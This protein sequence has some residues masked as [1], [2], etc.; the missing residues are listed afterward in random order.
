MSGSRVRPEYHNPIALNTGRAAALGWTAAATLLTVGAL[1]AANRLNLPRPSSAA[2]RPAAD[3]GH[4]ITVALGT[5]LLTM[6]WRVRR[7]RVELGLLASESL[8]APWKDQ[9]GEWFRGY[10][11]EERLLAISDLAD[12]WRRANSRKLTLL[13]ACAALPA[14]AGAIEGTHSL[15]VDE[16]GAQLPAFREVYFPLTIG[17][18]ESVV[19]LLLALVA[20]YACEALNDQFR[21]SLAK[22]ARAS[23]VKTSGNGGPARRRTT[24][25]RA[26]V[27]SELDASE[28][29]V[30]DHVSPSNG[31]HDFVARANHDFA[32]GSADGDAP[33]SSFT[34][35]P[36]ASPVLMPS[37]QQIDAS[38]IPD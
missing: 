11:R 7:A 14:L 22:L 32:D 9:S 27:H 31:E 3:V 12:S 23:T 25:D 16:S 6:A 1:V 34:Q 24:G 29:S 2:V 5:W 36:P 38:E 10:F 21:E 37:D 15:R 28:P 20:W 17:T 26:A 13:V 35:L 18:I 19:L 8:T 4:C 30:D 33:E